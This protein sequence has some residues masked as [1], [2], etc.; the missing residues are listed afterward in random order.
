[1][2]FDCDVVRTRGRQAHLQKRRGNL[3]HRKGFRAGG[4]K[5]IEIVQKLHK[6][7]AEQYF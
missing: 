7:Y 6:K 1:M 2:G 5:R 3:D 4:K